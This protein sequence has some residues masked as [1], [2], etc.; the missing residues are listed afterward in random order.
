M[1]AAAL[2]GVLVLL[3]AAACRAAATAWPRVAVASRLV[4]DPPMRAT[5]H[6]RDGRGVSWLAT[7]LQDVGAP[8][9][10][11]RVFRAWVV[12]TGVV[13]GAGIVLGG[14]ALATL[15]V[16]AVIAGPLVALRTGRS[17]GAARYAAQL[18]AVLD[19]IA[20][21]LRSGGSLHQAVGEAGAATPGPAGD[22]LR[23]VFHQAGRGMPLAD[24][25]EQWSERRPQPLVALA[26]AALALGVETGGAQARAI[27][28]VAATARDRLAVANEIRALS[29]QAR[30]SAVVITAAPLAFCALSATADPRTADFLLRTP[31]G[32][33][34]LIVGLALDAVAALWMARLTRV[35][36]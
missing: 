19:A 22:D 9:D 24:A 5:R 27:D 34:V 23:A 6:R 20:R 7:R 29:S 11:E 8:L 15:G 12:A 2:A 4:V 31:S 30:A 1:T 28:G 17:R 21:G 14:P 13:I 16:V 35:P 25:L 10:P 3:A 18:P 26:V 33:A 36:S 32:L